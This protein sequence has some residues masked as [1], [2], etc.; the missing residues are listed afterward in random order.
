MLLSA[1]GVAI[2]LVIRI[3]RVALLLRVM[4]FLWVTVLHIPLVVARLYLDKGNEITSV[5][6]ALAFSG[7]ALAIACM[8]DADDKKIKP[9]LH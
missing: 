1:S 5:F 8:Y 6:E 4:L 2:I 3:R 9:V 7:I